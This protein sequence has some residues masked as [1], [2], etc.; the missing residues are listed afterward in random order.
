M[1][2]GGNGEPFLWRY[3]GSRW[4]GLLFKAPQPV[5]LGISGF[6]GK[7]ILCQPMV[8]WKKTGTPCHERTY[9]TVFS[10]SGKLVQALKN[11]S[12]A[13]SISSSSPK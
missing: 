7:S 1:T 5:K 4:L 2:S 3:A 11:L 13:R 8:G 10:R 6:G 12:V 9:I